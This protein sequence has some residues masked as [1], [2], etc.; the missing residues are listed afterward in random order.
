MV[1]EPSIKQ[2]TVKMPVPLFQAVERN[3]K[4]KQKFVRD[5]IEKEI[6]ASGDK[7]Y[8][9]EMVNIYKNQSDNNKNNFLSK[10]EGIQNANAGKPA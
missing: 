10:V 7:K 3:T 6:I 1:K 2:I 8:I 9:Q 4:N 5:L